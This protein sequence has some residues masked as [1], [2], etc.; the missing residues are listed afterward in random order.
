[1]DLRISGVSYMQSMFK[2]ML[3]IFVFWCFIQKKRPFFCIFC[4]FF[5]YFCGKWKKVCQIVHFFRIPTWEKRKKCAKLP[6]FIKYR[7]AATFFLL[8]TYFFKQGAFNLHLNFLP[9]KSP[10]FDPPIFQEKPSLNQ[11]CEMWYDFPI[12][13]NYLEINNNN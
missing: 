10:F 9:K 7:S 4:S 2:K 1:M 6:I 3:W 12:L 11:T 5:A 8:T 13:D